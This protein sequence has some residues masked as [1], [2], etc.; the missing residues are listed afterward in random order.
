MQIILREDVPSLGKAGDVVKVRDGYARNYLLPRKLAMVADAKNLTAVE[1]HRKAI[2]KNTAKTRQGA[3]EMAD[4]LNQLEVTIARE[5]GVE[6]RLFG[7]VT[8]MDISEAL[9]KQGFRVDKHLI[10]LEAPIKAIGTFEIPIKLH[11]DISA[12][13]KLWVVREA[14]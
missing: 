12:T 1:V 8:R 9:G 6:D 2:E 3:Q 7:S 14:K 5:V 4:R 10:E 13:L 11:S